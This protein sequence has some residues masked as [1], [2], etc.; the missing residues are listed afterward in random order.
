MKRLRFI[1]LS[2]MLILSNHGLC[3]AQA[4]A[5]SGEPAWV[6]Y[7]KGLKELNAKNYG[8]ALYYLKAAIQTARV[9][10]EAELALGDLYFLQG[11]YLLAERQYLKAWEEQLAFQVPDEKYQALYRLARLYKLK[12]D[13]AKYETTLQKIVAAEPLFSDKLNAFFKDNLKR[14][15]INKG[16]DEAFKLNRMDEGF[17]TE[18]FAEL[19]WFYYRSYR[20][21][22]ALDFSLYSVI[23]ILSEAMKEIRA[24]FSGYQYTTLSDFFKQALSITYIKDYLAERNIYSRLYYLAL[25]SYELIKTRDIGIYLLNILAS[26]VEA[27]DYQRLARAQLAKPFREKSIEAELNPKRSLE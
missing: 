23:P 14:L 12:K 21:E 9:M 4:V 11:D 7:A 22:Y 20:F 18:A 15:Y 27:G 16:F 10:P 5:A 3:F 8:Q 25:N 13:F 19:A 26:L 17:A 2:L 1:V 6:A 24:N